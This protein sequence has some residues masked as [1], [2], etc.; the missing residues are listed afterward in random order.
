MAHKRNATLESLVQTLKQKVK[1]LSKQKANLRYKAKI[2]IENAKKSAKA[3]TKD[4]K[5]TVLHDTLGRFFTNAQISCFAKGDWKRKRNW[6]KDDFKRALSLKMLSTRA[7][8][9]LRQIQ[10]FP[11]PGKSTLASYFSSFVIAPGF[12]D[13]VAELVKFRVPQMSPT[14]KVCSL[15]MDEMHLTKAIGKHLKLRGLNRKFHI[16]IF[17]NFCR[18]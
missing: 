7:Y 12:L 13:S 8:D 16:I 10:A 17:F 9:Y 4:V 1:V 3:V 11:L 14:D 2:S 18:I 15:V 6:D 5:M